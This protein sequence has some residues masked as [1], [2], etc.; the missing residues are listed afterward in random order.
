LHA[1][2]RTN[3]LKTGYIFIAGGIVSKKYLLLVVVERLTSYFS[4]HV[5]QNFQ[6]K[7]MR[8]RPTK[9]SEGSM[10]FAPGDNNKEP[11][12]SLLSPVSDL[13]P[14]KQSGIL[15]FSICKLDISK[16]ASSCI[17]DHQAPTARFP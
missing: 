3:P 13:D 4:C 1:C 12:F 9:L 16:F 8:G 10:Y 11:Y 15:F 5:L 2:N 7:K 6:N 14:N 17:C